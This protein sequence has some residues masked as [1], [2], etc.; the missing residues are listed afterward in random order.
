MLTAARAVRLI[1]MLQEE[2]SL[3]VTDAAAR[4]GVS[5][6]TIRR[7]L[8]HLEGRGLASRVYG[9]AILEEGSERALEP[10]LVTRGSEHAAEKR[11]IGQAAARLVGENQTVLITGGTTTDS[12]L[13]FLGGRTRL[14]VLTNNLHTAIGTARHP[15]ITV[16]LLGGYL[17]RAE[18][19]LLG[20]LGAEAL[21]R[22]TVDR[23]FFGAYAVDTD[24]VMGAEVAETD[25]DRALITAAPHLV[26]LADSSKFTRR[27]PTRLASVSDI[28]TLVTDT[29]SPEDTLHRLR[30]QGVEIIRC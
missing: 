16:V 7:D 27:G 30:K 25:T 4:L 19:S 3:S 15:E 17:R 12:M 1:D 8:A 11:R 24:G 28:S 5:A 26:V 23:A 22:L 14:T 9:G 13:P 20:H 21:A 18:M 6:S 29:G 2:R 10:P